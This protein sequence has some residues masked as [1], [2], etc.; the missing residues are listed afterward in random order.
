MKGCSSHPKVDT[1]HA[2]NTH[3]NAL[4]SLFPIIYAALIIHKTKPSSYTSIDY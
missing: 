1:T 2:L 3:L 4:V